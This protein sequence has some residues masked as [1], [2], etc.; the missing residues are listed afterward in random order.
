MLR[1]INEHVA[2]TG[3][4]SKESFVYIT[5]LYDRQSGKCFSIITLSAFSLSVPPTNDGHACSSLF[6][7]CCF[8][9]TLLEVKLKKDRYWMTG[10]SLMRKSWKRTE[11]FNGEKTLRLSKNTVCCSGKTMNVSADYW[12][13]ISGITNQRNAENEKRRETRWEKS[14]FHLW[15]LKC[16]RWTYYQRSVSQ[17]NAS[18]QRS[19]RMAK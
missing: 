11:L 14:P 1:M 15:T 10:V 2:A 7:I 13:F 17:R 8:S 6:L 9:L 16:Q 18:E 19:D 3:W 5:G 12:S 4:S